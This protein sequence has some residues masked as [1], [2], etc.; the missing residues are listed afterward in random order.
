MGAIV[1]DASVILAALDPLDAFHGATVA[2]VRR[3]RESEDDFVLPASVLAQVLVGVARQGEDLLQTR[4]EAVSA[5]FGPVVELDASIAV[6]AAR[7]RARHA[8][9][10]LP[11]ALVLATA[12]ACGAKVILTGDRRWV[13]L[14]GRVELIRN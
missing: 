6:E 13:G 11:D 12:E 9:L 4:A 7:L 5:A 14:D 8:S 2:A 10:R 1:I 3:V